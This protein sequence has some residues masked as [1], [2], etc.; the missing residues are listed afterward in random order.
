MEATTRF[1]I[2]GLMCLRG[3]GFEK[4][5]YSIISGLEFSVYGAQEETEKEMAT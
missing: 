2:W 1:G 3:S 4:G 5:S